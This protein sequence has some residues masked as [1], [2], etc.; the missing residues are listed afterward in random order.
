MASHVF[1]DDNDKVVANEQEL[2][3][4]EEESENDS[5]ESDEDESDWSESESEESEDSTDYELELEDDK[6]EDKDE[7]PVPARDKDAGPKSDDNKSNFPLWKLPCL[8]RS[9]VTRLMEPYEVIELTMV[10]IPFKKFMMTF[11]L[12]DVALKFKFRESR[13]IGWH[14]GHLRQN[15]FGIDLGFPNRRG[16]SL[17][18]PFPKKT[19][20]GVRRNVNG[21]PMLVENCDGHF[22]F[23]GHRKMKKKMKYMERM[24][25]H[26]TEV[27]RVTKYSLEYDGGVEK[28]KLF[29]CF[30]WNFVKKFDKIKIGCKYIE[31]GMTRDQVRFLLNNVKCDK[32]VLNVLVFGKVKDLQIKS[33]ILVVGDEGDWLT[34]DSIIESECEKVI[35]EIGQEKPSKTAKLVKKWQTGKKLTNLKKLKLTLRGDQSP[36]LEIID[37]LDGVEMLTKTEER[38]LKKSEMGSRFPPGRLRKIRRATDGKIAVLGVHERCVEMRVLEN[39]DPL[40]KF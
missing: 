14:R 10:S 32:V 5:S 18:F 37:K 15:N 16:I 28:L 20:A 25:T 13:P 17:V 4:E 24:A 19:F 33:K 39:E 36:A 29:K 21:K 30:V 7:E 27:C 6:P 9:L 34:V 23:G 12:P 8:A 38:V 31:F 11:K 3:N 35:G 2:V 26:L 22:V 40:K 1:G